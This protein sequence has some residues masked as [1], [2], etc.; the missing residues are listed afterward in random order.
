M[1]SVTVPV[2]ASTGW[3]DLK[4][5]EQVA[6]FVR[7]RTQGGSQAARDRSRLVIRPLD[8]IN[9]SGSYPDRYFGILS[10]A[11]LSA[12]HVEFFN[13][14]IR[15]VEPTASASRVRIFVMGIDQWRDETDW[16]LPDTAYTDFHLNSS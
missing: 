7:V 6:D 1:D 4:V 15:G 8:H 11:D 10:A 16:P 14:Q 12:S 13:Q 2:L 3:F 5:H 9:L